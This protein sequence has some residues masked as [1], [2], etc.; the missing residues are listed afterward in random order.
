MEELLEMKNMIYDK[1]CKRIS[2]VDEQGAC[3]VILIDFFAMSLTGTRL[4]VNCHL[5]SVGNEKQLNANL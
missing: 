4:N 3:C 5:I 2:K 1:L